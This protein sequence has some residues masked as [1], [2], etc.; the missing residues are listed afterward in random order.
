VGYP[1]AYGAHLW[2]LIFV[3]IEDSLG[4]N[5]CSFKN[6]PAFLLF[7]FF[8]EL[9]P[10]Y[11]WRLFGPDPSNFLGNGIIILVNGNIFTGSCNRVDNI[12]QRFHNPNHF[13]SSHIVQCTSA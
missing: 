10:L 4:G 6:W 5:V 2:G 7:E 13:I 3:S 1:T 11:L 12:L 8:L 9:V